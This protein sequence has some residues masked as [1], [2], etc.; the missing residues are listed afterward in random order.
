M[1]KIS[2]SLSRPS[3]NS[4]SPKKLL[5]NLGTGV[6]MPILAPK[7]NSFTYLLSTYQVSAGHERFQS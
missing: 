1:N 2:V 4:I 7:S 5:K 3:E 6:K